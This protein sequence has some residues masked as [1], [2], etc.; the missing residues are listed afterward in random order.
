MFVCLSDPQ[1]SLVNR[2]IHTFP[3]QVT[4]TLVQPHALSLSLHKRSVARGH[5]LSIYID[6]IVIPYSIA[7]S[8]HLEVLEY[9]EIIT[10]KW[11]EIGSIPL[12]VNGGHVNVK[13]STL[14]SGESQKTH[15][16]PHASRKLDLDL[17]EPV[18]EKPQED[19]EVC[20]E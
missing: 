17:K 16:Q 19:V 2:T 3:Y 6:N 20:N 8:A 9:K 15:H 4:V 14:S 7:C 11:R 13:S 12:V 1:L 10:P 18:Q 5:H